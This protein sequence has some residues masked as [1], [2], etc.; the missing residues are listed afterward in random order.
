MRLS[1]RWENAFSPPSPHSSQRV[2]NQDFVFFSSRGREIL[3]FP[4]A[5]PFFLFPLPSKREISQFSGWFRRWRKKKRKKGWKTL[6]FS[7]SAVVIA[8]SHP[9]SPPPKLNFPAE[10]GKRL[11]SFSR[12]RWRKITLPSFL[13]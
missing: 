1:K 10:E 7:F 12:F 11:V 8:S 4:P 13:S 9:P 5:S 2:K 6:I 3:N